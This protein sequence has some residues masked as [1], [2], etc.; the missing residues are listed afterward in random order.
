MSAIPA[1]TDCDDF[2]LES[3]YDEEIRPLSNA[4]HEACVKN[5]IPLLSFACFSRKEGRSGIATSAVLN[6]GGGRR[7]EL[8]TLFA[9]ISSG[10]ISPRYGAIQM[11]QQDVENFT[12]DKSNSADFAERIMIMKKAQEEASLLE[13]SCCD[14][15]DEDLFDLT[16][17]FKEEFE[18]LIMQL[19]DL[20]KQYNMPLQLYANFK[21]D[22]SS[23]SCALMMHGPRERMPLKMA[24]AEKLLNTSQDVGA[25]EV[26]DERD[27]MMELV[28]ALMKRAKSSTGTNG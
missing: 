9:G 12:S 14:D 18:P 26:K 28:D 6:P 16:E 17:V 8:L 20:A 24:L 19:R 1:K 3:V 13:T 11:L 21:H 7:V 2:D 15:S 25:E 5:K 4:L 22:G 27:V 23:R 10:I